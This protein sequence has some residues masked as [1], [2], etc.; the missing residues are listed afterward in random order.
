MEEWAVF[1]A[2]PGSEVRRFD[3][4]NISHLGMHGVPR[5]MGLNCQVFP[6]CHPSATNG[7]SVRPLP[8]S[9]A[10]QH[11]T[12]VP[13]HLLPKGALEAAAASTPTARRQGEHLE[14]ARSRQAP[15]GL[16]LSVQLCP[17]SQLRRLL[18][19]NLHQQHR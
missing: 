3:K 9:A 10:V 16:L 6:R 1:S 17:R 14:T 5:G 15:Q 13:Q 4:V 11:S 8:R 2:H 7:S 12:A 19:R 18:G